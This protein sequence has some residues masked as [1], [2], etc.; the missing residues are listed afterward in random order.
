MNQPLKIKLQKVTEDA[1]MPIKGT[2]DAACYDVYAHSITV[3]NDG[4]VT[5]GLGFKTEIPKGYKG[6]IVPRSN[7]TK[8]FWVLN[9][10]FGVIDSDYRGEWMAIFTPVPILSG[11]VSGTTSFPY[12]VGDRVAQIY[13]EEVLPISF[14]VV[15]ELEQSVRGE[16]GFGSTGLK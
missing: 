3:S 10:S 5:V 4:K 12:G 9:N 15:P 16:A 8:Y 2:A 6:I 1:R 7:L 11:I 13:F 14:D